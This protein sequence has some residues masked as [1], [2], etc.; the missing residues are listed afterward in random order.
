M[1]PLD[2]KYQGV[3]L[4]TLTVVDRDH[5]VGRFWNARC[6]CGAIVRILSSQVKDGSR[7]ACGVGCP[8]KVDR[9]ARKTN[10]DPTFMS[11]KSM[12]A[13]CSNP[14]ATSYEIYGG[15]GISV[16]ERWRRFENFKQDMGERRSRD[17]SL[18]RIDVNGNYEPANCR[19]ATLKQQA[20]NTRATKLEPHEPEQMRWLA[21][22][23]YSHREI[24]AFFGIS[25]TGAN[26]V[27]R[28]RTWAP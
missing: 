21:S 28:G 23:G 2:F 5:I 17:Y 27:I 1:K 6:D 14:K 7:K 25:Q 10:S 18:D 4:G 16:C 12:L 22:L 24:G 9:R 11:W 13:R 26:A 20:R 8:I 15:R 19:W 3:R